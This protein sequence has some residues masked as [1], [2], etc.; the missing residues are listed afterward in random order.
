MEKQR[1][2]RKKLT[3]DEEQQVYQDILKTKHASTFLDDIKINIKCKTPN[4]KILINLIKQKE[5]TICSGPAGSGK[6]YLA[7]AMALDLLKHDPKYKQIYLVKSVTTLKEEE[8]GFLKGTMEEKMKPFMFSFL[9]NFA[10]LIGEQETENLKAGGYIK[11]MP[12]AY[13]RGINID[14]AV[15]ICDEVQNISIDNMRTIMTRLG[16]D[17]KMIFLGDE[18]QI[19]IKKKEL[20]SLRK[21][22]NAFAD[23]DDI[24]SLTLTDDDVVRN[25]LITTIETVF[26]GL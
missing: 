17:S 3:K 4:Q 23:V 14:N 7:C 20:S 18:N 16:E 24:G 2:R 26:R 19:D 1:T 6:T 13:M 22:I 5:I 11:E 10:K 9:H 8:I 12:I 25:K 15:V 21:I